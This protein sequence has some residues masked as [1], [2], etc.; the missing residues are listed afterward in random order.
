MT[1]LR[2]KAK[3]VKFSVGDMIIDLM[4][5]SIGVLIRRHRRIDIVRD[6]VYVWE[7]IWS[8]ESNKPYDVPN[9][10]YMEEEGLKLSVVAGMY[11]WHRIECSILTLS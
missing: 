2:D 9:S 8:S 11:D 4:I 1:K 5:G 7:I 10:R 3:Y 6:D